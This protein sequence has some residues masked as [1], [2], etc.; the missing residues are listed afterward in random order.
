MKHCLQGHQWGIL[1]HTCR[2]ESKIRT[3]KIGGSIILHPGPPSWHFIFSNPL[4]IHFYQSKN[5][6][7]GFGTLTNRDQDRTLLGLVTFFWPWGWGAFLVVS[8][9]RP[10]LFHFLMVCFIADNENEWRKYW[11][12]IWFSNFF[13]FFR[14]RNTPKDNRILYSSQWKSREGEGIYF[15][16]RFDWEKI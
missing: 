4:T 5:Q 10:L 2:N 15:F 7:L 12:E 14:M 8:K 11:V 6:N 9:L 1:F 16:F 13:L 3:L